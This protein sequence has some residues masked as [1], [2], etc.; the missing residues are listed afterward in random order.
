VSVPAKHEATVVLFFAT[1]SAPDMKLVSHLEEIALLHPELAV[2]AISI[3]DEDRRVLEAAASRGARYPIVWDAG[4]ALAH[5]YGVRMDPTT[6]VLDRQ[7]I[8]RFVHEGF[9]D[10]EQYAID[11]E[12]VSLLGKDVCRRPL[13]TKSG[14]VCFHQCERMAKASADCTTAECRARCAGP[15]RTCHE[16]CARENAPRNA[17]LA[18]CR[19]KRPTRRE[20]CEAAC[21]SEEMSNA[22]DACEF[23]SAGQPAL[24]E[25]CAAACGVRECRDG[26]SRLK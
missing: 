2:V 3:D 14:P 24:R 21:H 12:V 25:E 19:R 18:I 4:H 1:W 22:I 16:T 20:A 5:T 15:A 17:A 13:P 7:G 6:L 11:D 10:D 26:C 9:H 23:H 8:V